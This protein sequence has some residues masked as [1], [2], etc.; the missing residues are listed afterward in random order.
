ML[1]IVDVSG[2]VP[3]QGS[4]GGGGFCHHSEMCGEKEGPLCGS[5]FHLLETLAEEFRM[6]GGAV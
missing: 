5:D 1:C 4:S 2:L 6:Q 3:S